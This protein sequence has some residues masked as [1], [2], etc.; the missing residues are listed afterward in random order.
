MSTPYYYALIPLARD[1]DITTEA[2]TSRLAARL[3]EYQVAHQDNRVTVAQG[4]WSL[5]VAL[6]TED[7]INAEANEMADMHPDWPNLE[8]LRE[9]SKRLEL[10][11]YCDDSG[12]DHFNTYLFVLEEIDEFNGILFKFDPRDGGLM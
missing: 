6:S 10:F 4:D 7:W 8:K 1:A 12:M 11:S 5:S 3:P 2:L 9:S